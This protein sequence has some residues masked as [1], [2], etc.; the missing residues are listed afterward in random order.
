MNGVITGRRRNSFCR[1]NSF[2]IFTKIFFFLSFLKEKHSDLYRE[3]PE[4][5]LKVFYSNC[6]TVFF[7]QCR[8]FSSMPFFLNVLFVEKVIVEYFDGHT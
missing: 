6:D 7:L 4:K 5:I 2:Y 8:F 3:G 1:K